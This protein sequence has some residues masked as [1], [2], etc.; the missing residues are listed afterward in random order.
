MVYNARRRDCGARSNMIDTKDLDI[1]AG[2]LLDHSIGGVTAD[3]RVMIK[4]EAVCWPLMAVLEQKVVDAGGVPDV[5]VVAPNNERGRVWSAGMARSASEDQLGRI[6]AWHGDRYNT[7]T[8]YVEILG[9]E[10][11]EQFMG[12]TAHPP[13]QTMGHH[14]LSDR[15]VGRARRDGLRHV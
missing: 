12:L 9:A 13:L 7:M 4:G 10:D 6:P 8:K 14:P 11:P 5:Y 15:S 1:W 3:D 2:F